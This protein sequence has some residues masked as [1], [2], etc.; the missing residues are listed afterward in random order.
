MNGLLWFTGKCSFS[1]IYSVMYMCTLQAICTLG[2]YNS[3]TPLCDVLIILIE[4]RQKLEDL[5]IGLGLSLYF[6]TF[7]VHS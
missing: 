3:T 1:T 5:L 7:I 2:T 6:I 4:V